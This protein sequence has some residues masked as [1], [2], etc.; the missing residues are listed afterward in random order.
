MKKLFFIY[1][2]FCTTNILSAQN[3]PSPK[4]FLGYE[5][6]EHFT[7]AYKIDSYFN[8]V[9]QAA[10]SMVKVQ[11]YGTTN[12]GRDMLV[13]IISS[14][15][16]IQNIDN[17]RMNN[18]RLAG[19]LKDNTPADVNAPA[20]VWLSYSVHGNEPAGSEASMK[21]LYALTDA[22]NAQAKQWL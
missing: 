15:Q 6:G 1:L 22:S 17:I 21:V 19:M 20:I 14:P 9:A 18:L 11:H 4:Q 12:E 13:G 8:A 3:I 10:P 16:N 2:L 5:P 7:P